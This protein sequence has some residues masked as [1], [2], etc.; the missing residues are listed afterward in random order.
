MAAASP[1]RAAAGGTLSAVQ[2]KPFFTV[3]FAYK[4]QKCDILV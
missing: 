2:D 3:L 1:P 4:M